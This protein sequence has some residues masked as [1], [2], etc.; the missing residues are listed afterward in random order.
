M[1]K[2]LGTAGL[3]L[4]M[5]VLGGVALFGDAL[6][7]CGTTVGEVAQQPM[8]HDTVGLASYAAT[9]VESAGGLGALA[10]A[11]ML[12]GGIVGAVLCALGVWAIWSR[13]AAPR[14]VNLAGAGAGPIQ[15]PGRRLGGPEES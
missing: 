6:R 2:A 14:T 8:Q 5:L 13:P 1:A 7:A 4:V 15:T 12:Y 11:V 10:G 3:L 9:G